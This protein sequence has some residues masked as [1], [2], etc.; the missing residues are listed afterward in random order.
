MPEAV[1][2]QTTAEKKNTEAIREIAESRRSVRQFL[3][4]PVPDADISE[5]LRLTGL[6]PSA[7]NAQPWR[8]AVVRTPDMLEQLAEV[9]TGNNVATVR[10]APACIVL[11]SDG[12]EI[13]DTLE[14][15]MHP[16]LGAEEMAK[17]A[18]NL[19]RSL[20]ART[21]EDLV[22]WARLQ[23]YIALGQFVLIARGLGYDSVTMGGFREDGVRELLG[24]PETAGITSVIALGRR[25]QAGFSHHRHAVERVTRW[26]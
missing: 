7:A 26:Y 4:E 15:V 14:E 1:L 22:S 23:T 10:G 5:I 21:P 6:A 20:S 9:M 25:S 2:E 17:R 13:V 11:Y 19:R 3:A 24:L 18:G 12:A 16:G 8:W